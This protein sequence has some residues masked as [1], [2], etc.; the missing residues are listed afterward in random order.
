MARSRD[1]AAEYRRQV[2]LARQE[3]YASVRER[4]RA[5]AERRAQGLS[6][7][8][9]AQQRQRDYAAE[10]RRQLEIARDLGYRSV[11]E[12][13]RKRRMWGSSADSNEAILREILDT[14]RNQPY[15]R[16]RP[17]LWQS[18]SKELERLIG[19]EYRQWCAEWYN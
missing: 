6:N 18:Q 7:R 19:E 13:K 1:Y 4:K 11:R 2:E 15:Q 9:P 16:G 17:R 8:R 14:I 10:Y 5:Q 12:R 3:G